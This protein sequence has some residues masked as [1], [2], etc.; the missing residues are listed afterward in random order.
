M[1][2]AAWVAAAAAPSAR[3]SGAASWPTEAF[4]DPYSS[5]ASAQ[6]LSASVNQSASSSALGITRE[7]GVSDVGVP[8]SETV[9]G[10]GD[11]DDCVTV[12]TTVSGPAPPRL[13]EH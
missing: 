11:S 3:S 5:M 9:G 13:P 10:V 12:V 2:S 8:G 4:H 6:A 7:D 1:A